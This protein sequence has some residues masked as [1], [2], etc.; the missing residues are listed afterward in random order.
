[1]NEGI[2]SHLVD[3]KSQLCPYSH[4]VRFPSDDHCLLTF[5]TTHLFLLTD[6]LKREIRFRLPARQSTGTRALDLHVWASFLFQ[7]L[8]RIINSEEAT[9]VGDFRSCLSAGSS[10]PRVTGRGAI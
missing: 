3:L 5:R 7:V 10:V 8:V 4:S 2:R 1:M 6:L 9:S